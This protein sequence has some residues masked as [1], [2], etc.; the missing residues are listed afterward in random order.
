M[1]TWLLPDHIEDVLPAE[2]RRIEAARRALLD[3]F[4][5]HGYELVMPPLVEHLDA[6]LTGTGSDMALDTFKLVDP[7]SGELLGVRADITPQAA[8]IDA[9]LL[10]R[11]GVT[12]LC[13]AGSVLHARPHAGPSR[14]P[15][16]VGA[17]L[18]GH[19]GIEADLEVQTLMLKALALLG[20]P[21]VQLDLGHVGIFRA[22]M[23]RAGVTPELEQALFQALQAKDAA[24][25]EALS[26]GLD[27]ETR[28]AL[29]ALPGM[30]GGRAVLERAAG[31]LPR[32]PEIGR[33]LDVLATLADALEAAGATLHFDL[34]ELRGYHYH[35]G[36]VF[37]AYAP[38]AATAVAQGGRYDNV[39]QAFGR[40]RCATGFSLDLRALVARLPNT[41]MRAAILA[42]SVRDQALAARIEAL[43]AAGETVV[44]ALPGEGPEDAGCTRRLVKRG[45]AWEIESI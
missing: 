31:G 18:F 15:L 43:R 12:R 2:A 1:R 25:L 37:A 9:H 4:A 45:D 44:V 32:W 17:E 36:V 26:Q 42:P 40:A 28:A 34:A 38:G 16:Q 35:N 11:A 3:L 22:L 33:A 10:N 30:Y 8:R 23:A 24:T 29:A 6:L 5:V 27:G 39:G 41:A 20:L 14:E 13:Y 7:L 19:A 21:A